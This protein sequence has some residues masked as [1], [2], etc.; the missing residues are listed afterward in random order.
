VMNRL[1]ECFTVSCEEGVKNVG[2]QTIP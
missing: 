2:R 1:D